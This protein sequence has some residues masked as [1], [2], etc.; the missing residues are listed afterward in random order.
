MNFNEF[1]A[2]IQKQFE[3]MTNDAKMI[4]ETGVVKDAMWDMYLDS[5]PAAAN[6]IYRQRHEHDC[7]CCRHFVKSIGNA[8]TLKNGAIT[9]IWDVHV[10]DPAYQE[11]ADAMSAY[12][13][14][15]PIVNC[16]HTVENAVGTDFNY[17]LIDGKRLPFDEKEI[18]KAAFAQKI[19]KEGTK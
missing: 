12:V 6:P 3:S 4:F 9:S 13:K 19:K 8:V 2:A 1:R 18:V 15:H 11:V 7:S 14:S 5:F 16:W 17:E 10:D